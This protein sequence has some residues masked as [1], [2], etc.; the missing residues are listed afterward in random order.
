MKIVGMFQKLKIGSILAWWQVETMEASEDIMVEHI[1]VYIG[2]NGII[3]ANKDCSRLFGSLI[4][5]RP[6]ETSDLYGPCIDGLD[7]LVVTNETTRMD[8]MFYGISSQS[9][10][11]PFW[12]RRTW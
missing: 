7:R 5:L 8:Y 10:E 6:V 12:D 4:H 9:D 2:S 3:L 1:R 11:L